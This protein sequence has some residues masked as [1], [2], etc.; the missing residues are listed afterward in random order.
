ME[1][2][3]EKH[4]QIFKA[5]TRGIHEDSWKGNERREGGKEKKMSG[6]SFTKL[7]IEQF[8]PQLLFRLLVPP[9]FVGNLPE[10]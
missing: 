3:V 10:L 4:P 5:T 7:L 2:D 6:G 8:H 9:D 1:E